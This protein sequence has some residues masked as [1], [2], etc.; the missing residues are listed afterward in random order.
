MRHAL[1]NLVA[2]LTPGLS[3]GTNRR[4]VERGEKEENHE[5]YHPLT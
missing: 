4:L 1:P 3:P 5:R 2:A